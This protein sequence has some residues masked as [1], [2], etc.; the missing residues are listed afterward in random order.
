MSWVAVAMLWVAVLGACAPVWSQ[1]NPEPEP[2]EGED[3]S[4]RSQDP[5]NRFLPPEIRE[6]VEHPQPAESEEPGAAP[7]GAAEPA[8]EAPPVAPP[9]VPPAAAPAAEPAP[10]APPVRKSRSA[11][12]KAR[13]AAKARERARVERAGRD[14]KSMEE[15]RRRIEAEAKADKLEAERVQRQLEREARSRTRSGRSKKKKG[16]PVFPSAAPVTAGGGAPSP[17]P[18]GPAVPL[19]I[20]S[21]GPR[22]EAAGGGSMGLGMGDAVARLRSFLTGQPAP[23]PTPSPVPGRKKSKKKRG[24]QE[25]AVGLPGSVPGSSASASAASSDQGEGRPR[26]RREEYGRTGEEAVIRISASD[27]DVVRPVTQPVPMIEP[28]KQVLFALADKPRIPLEQDL[29]ISYLGYLGDTSRLAAVAKRMEDPKLTDEQKLPLLAVLADSSGDTSCKPALYRIVDAPASPPFLR[30]WALEILSRLGDT[31]RIGAIQKLVDDPKTGQSEQLRGLAILADLGDSTRAGLARKLSTDGSLFL[32]TR[33]QALFILSR[34][35]P[36]AG[37]VEMKKH[38]NAQKLSVEERLSI[39]LDL[40]QQGDSAA[41]DLFLRVVENEADTVFD[42]LRALHGLALLGRCV[43]L[44][45]LTQVVQTRK[46]PRAVALRIGIMMGDRSRVPELLTEAKT[47]DLEALRTLVLAHLLDT[48]KAAPGD[49]H[50]Q[51][52]FR[53]LVA[54]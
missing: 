33:L 49:L 47:G 44:G 28:L 40:A 34:M 26:K 12:A 3:Q 25:A 22:P 13:A 9:A 8:P 32:A 31:S 39:A 41:C 46:K 15:K 35:D 53:S 7:D 29:A 10:E 6:D 18:S 27:R 51:P 43:H 24:A 45:L 48:Q 37:T 50:K 17:S 30:L 42:Q 19:E 23:S 11:K 1:R 36:K 2:V 54:P 21:T 16:D 14:D 20:G 4:P 52:R 38:M 5:E